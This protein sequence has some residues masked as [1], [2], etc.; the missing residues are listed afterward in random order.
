[1]VELS[2]TL[3]II[4]HK[5]WIWHYLL[6]L[7]LGKATRRS[8]IHENR[9]AIRSA[10]WFLIWGKKENRRSLPLL[11]CIFLWGRP[12]LKSL[13]IMRFSLVILADV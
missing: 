1:M 7:L 10:D 8:D 11:Q 3:S 13:K 12:R 2:Y 9:L 4:S 5:V 6:L